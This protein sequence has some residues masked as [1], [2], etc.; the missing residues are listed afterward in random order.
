MAPVTSWDTAAEGNATECLLLLLSL[1]W[2]HTCPA[3]ATAKGSWCHLHL[4]EG[5]C[6]FP[7]LYN[8]EQ[9]AAPPMGPHHCQGL[10]NQTSSGYRPCPLP[11]SPWN[12]AQ[13]VHQHTPYQVDNSLQTLSKESGCIQTKSSPHAKKK[14]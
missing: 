8:Q 12:L 7:G 4:P 13:I 9:P 11:P 10:S 2:K 3:V 5:H 14:N 6:H 1:P